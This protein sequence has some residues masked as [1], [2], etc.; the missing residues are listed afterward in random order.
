MATH[1]SFDRADDV[2]LP[3]ERSFGL[4]FAAF[5]A[6]VACAPL[7]HD[8]SGGPRWWSGAL[9]LLFLLCGFFWTAPLKPLNR[10]WSRFGMLLHAVVSPLVMGVMFFLVIAPIGFLMK[11]FGQDP[12]RLRLDRSARSYWIMRAPPG[13]S[14]ESMK[15][16]F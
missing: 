3:S 12:L 7:L 1:E 6:I 16:Q 5:F 2:K 8:F 14:A 4:V 13:P 9:A 10:L 15:N 11:L